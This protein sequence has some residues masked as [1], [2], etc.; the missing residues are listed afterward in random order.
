MNGRL[1]AEGVGRLSRRELLG[2]V[3]AAPWI[4]GSVACGGRFSRSYGLLGV[5]ETELALPDPLAVG[6]AVV[7]SS[8]AGLDAAAL[9]RELL[10]G[11]PASADE[12]AI[13]TA[14]RNRSRDDFANERR[15]VVEGWRLSRTEGLLC[16]AL[17]LE[18]ASGDDRPS[19]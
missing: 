10:D 16:A 6:R 11:L 19:P 2:F 8:E 7:A 13:A 15:L 4:V 5:L 1:I 18:A 14:F 3:A 17:A 9:W 12:D